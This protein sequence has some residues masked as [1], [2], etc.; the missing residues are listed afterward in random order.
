MK[1]LLGSPLQFRNPRPA[2]TEQH[3]PATEHEP[4]VAVAHNHN[5]SWI[6]MMVMAGMCLLVLI[7]AGSLNVG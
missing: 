6:A 7:Y 2:M 4:K 1:L 5:L 3:T